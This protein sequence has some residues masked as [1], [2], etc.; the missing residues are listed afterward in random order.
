MLVS[1]HTITEVVSPQRTINGL[2]IRRND[3]WM[4]SPQETRQVNI[5]TII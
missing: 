1:K 2:T 3:T 5:K 4:V